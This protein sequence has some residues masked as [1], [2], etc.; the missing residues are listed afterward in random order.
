M[1][2]LLKKTV[3]SGLF[4]LLLGCV[5]FSPEESIGGHSPLPDTNACKADRLQPFRV[6]SLPRLA[7]SEN[8]LHLI[9]PGGEAA[10]RPVLGR[11]K[12]HFAYTVR[13][14]TYPS[15]EGHGKEV[16]AYFY[17]PSGEHSLPA[18]LI[19]PITDGDYFTEHFARFLAE[20][21]FAI[22]QYESRGEIRERISPN[23]T[24]RVALRH[25][26][27]YLQAYVVDV[28]R[29]IDW[30]ESQPRIDRARIGLFGI[31]Q[32][33]IVGSLVA[34]LDPRVRSGVFIL[35]GGGL[36]GILSSTEERSLAQIRERILL[37]GEFSQESFHQEADTTFS[38]VDPLTYAHCIQSSAMLLVNARFDRV[39]LPP[40][41]EILW[42]KMGKPPRI[43]LPAGHYT[44]SLFLPYIRFATLRHFQSTL[45]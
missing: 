12:S 34:G 10:I 17:R 27:N 13:K 18:V 19:L 20:Q 32:G 35:G 25:F 21:G 2:P 8:D 22:L 42:E 39:I 36:A 11:E 41:A 45:E 43:Q 3:C 7:S 33:A 44:A 40:Y 30:L 1:F 23:Q 38:P 4:L 29:G 16:H 5:T 6:G 31:S 9:S 24:G 37:S 26:R 14:L 15:V 28:L